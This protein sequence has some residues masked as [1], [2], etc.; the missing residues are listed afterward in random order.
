MCPPCW[1]WDLHHGQVFGAAFAFR[2]EGPTLRPA[3]SGSPSAGGSGG[4]SA[5]S[6]GV[7]AASSTEAR[8]GAVPAGAETLVDAVTGGPTFQLQKEEVEWVR[9]VPLKEVRHHQ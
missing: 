2:A 5:S 8:E 3:S 1:M 7:P 6:G 9:W 4:P